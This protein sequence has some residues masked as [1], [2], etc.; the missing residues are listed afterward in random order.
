MRLDSG[1]TQHKVTTANRRSGHFVAH[2]VGWL[3]SCYYFGEYAGMHR[4]G[5]IHTRRILRR[6]QER[7][8]SW[9]A[10]ACAQ[11][12]QSSMHSQQSSALLIFLR[13]NAGTTH[14]L[15]L[16][17]LEFFKSWKRS[18][19]AALHV[20][21]MCTTVISKN[22]HFGMEPLVIDTDTYQNAIKFLRSKQGDVVQCIAAAHRASR[23]SPLP[24]LLV[25]G[26]LDA[27]RVD[28]TARGMPPERPGRLES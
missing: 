28:G 19:Q 23:K 1:K 8:R 17:M 3:P 22:L 14:P 26:V 10:Q 25:P 6:K 2:L 12:L 5:A 13:K 15:H 4:C 11:Q 27:E 9:A 24:E 21:F 18:K 20:V 16:S 7:S